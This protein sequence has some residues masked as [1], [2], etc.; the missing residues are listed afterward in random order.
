MAKNTRLS[1]NGRGLWNYGLW[2]GL[3]AS[4]AWPGMLG[5]PSCLYSDWQLWAGPG[6]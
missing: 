4:W 5:L 3:Q 2:E 1:D 6:P